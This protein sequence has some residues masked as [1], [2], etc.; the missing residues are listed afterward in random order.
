M[1]EP[2]SQNRFDIVVIG[3]GIVG[4]SCALWLQL[5]GKKVLLVDRDEPGSGTSY[6]NAC[7]IATYGCV[8]VNSPSLFYKLPGMLCSSQSPLSIDIGYAIANL[9]WMLSF[10]RHCTPARVA[11]TTRALGSLL[12]HTDEGLDPLIEKSNTADLFVQNDCLY[13]YS[14]TQSFRDAQSSTQARRDNGTDLQVLTRDDV[15]RLEPAIKLEFHRAL[16]FKGARHVKNPRALVSRFVKSLCAD[17]GR[18]L[19]EA[20]SEIQ[21]HSDHVV[22]QTGR[23]QTLK[24]DYCVVSAGAHSRHIAGAGMELLPLDTERGYHIQFQQHQELLSRPVGW[25]D[26]GFYATPTNEGLRCAG[27]VEIGGLAKPINEKRIEYI[28]RMTRRLFG[29][30]GDPSTQWLGFRPTFP[31]SLPMIGFAENSN[32]ILI[33]TGHHHLGLTL[34]GI[35][36]KV[37]SE[38]I[39]E[40]KPSLDLTPFDTHRF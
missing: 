38:L 23:G 19:K 7:T 40:Q 29:D 39:C 31:D 32:R 22:I 17:G 3:A 24:A 2:E 30:L 27:T 13:L 36:G 18:F 11:H 28:K 34:G 10:L 1:T 12:R 9:P 33:A 6:G 8:P 26:A 15:L 14:T 16:Q 4:A 21:Q 37:I 35:T 20:A 25:A 5:Q